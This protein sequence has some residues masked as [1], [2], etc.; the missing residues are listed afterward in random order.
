MRLLK[1]IIGRWPQE[2]LFLVGDDTFLAR[3]GIQSFRS[4]YAP[5]RLPEHAEP[6][7]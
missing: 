2:M 7:R 5:R 3:K 4:G 1:L 6:N